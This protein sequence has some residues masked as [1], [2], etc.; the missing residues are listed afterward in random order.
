MTFHHFHGQVMW[1][2]Y[3][4]TDADVLHFSNLFV[5]EAQAAREAGDRDGERLAHHLHAE[6]AGAYGES[7]AH[8][9][10]PQQQGR[11]AA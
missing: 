10:E 9:S 3:A 1:G 4:L 11:A 2:R 7:I 8:R 5:D 6:L